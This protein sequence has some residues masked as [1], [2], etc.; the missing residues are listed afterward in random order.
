MHVRPDENQKKTNGFFF[1]KE[2][3]R[4]WLS[5]SKSL[6]SAVRGSVVYDGVEEWEGNSFHRRNFVDGVHLGLFFSSIQQNLRS[7]ICIAKQALTGL[8]ALHEQGLVHGNIHVHNLIITAHTMEPLWVDHS[9]QGSK[10]E[11]LI[12]FRRMF[13]ENAFRDDVEIDLFCVHFEQSVDVVLFLQQWSQEKPI[14][15]RKLISDYWK[16]SSIEQ[17]RE[18]LPVVDSI[19]QIVDEEECVAWEKLLEQGYKG[20]ELALLFLER[21]LPVENKRTLLQDVAEGILLGRLS[22][23]TSKRYRARFTSKEPQGRDLSAMAEQAVE[24]AKRVQDLE[25]EIDNLESRSWYERTF[26][27]TKEELQESKA[28]FSQALHE[29]DQVLPKLIP[30]ARGILDNKV[31]LKIAMLKKEKLDASAKQT[32]NTDEWFPRKV[33]DAKWIHPLGRQERSVRIG[34]TSLTFRLIPQGFWGDM[35]MVEPLWISTELISQGLYEYV[36]ENNPSRHLGEDIP[37]HMVSF[38]SVLHFC[39][40]FSQRYAVPNPYLFSG[41]EWSLE[42][43]AGFRLLSKE[44]WSYAARAMQSMPKGEEL[45]TQAWCWNNSGGR[46]HAIGQRKPNAWGLYDIWGGLEE[47]VWAHDTGGSSRIG[48]SWYHDQYA[49]DCEQV[50]TGPYDLNAD[51]IGFRIAISGRFPVTDEEI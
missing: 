27:P 16:P 25:E 4:L 8:C 29:R 18:D 45:R 49:L 48:G 36:V 13:I 15:N 38:D 6:L 5:S 2:N 43:T 1:E 21:F 19:E 51:T 40:R 17:K 23:Q 34:D 47:W 7:Y 3:M 20:K 30:M 32:S 22:I 26:G 41:G 35:A 46:I 14:W 24:A 44:E 31:A 39:N 33:Y 11:D 42:T 37:V 9:N 12:A 10:E 50:H 28:L